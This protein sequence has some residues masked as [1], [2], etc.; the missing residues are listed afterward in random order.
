MCSHCVWILFLCETV[1]VQGWQGLFV[2]NVHDFDF[3]SKLPKLKAQGGKENGCG[4]KLQL[5]AREA[6]LLVALLGYYDAQ[7]RTGQKAGGFVF[8][9][10]W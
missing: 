10:L 3:Y 2:R 9:L 5:G 8:Q 1:E 6:G 7:A 4:G